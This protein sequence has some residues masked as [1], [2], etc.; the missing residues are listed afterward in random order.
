MLNII[1]FYFQ[2]ANFAAEDLKKLVNIK[3]GRQWCSYRNM[4]QMEKYVL[5]NQLPILQAPKT[6]KRDARLFVTFRPGEKISNEISV[7]LDY[8]FNKNN[9][10][11]ATFRK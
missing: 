2:L 4:K 11:L 1:L 5:L 3:I 9:S 7:T 8:E 10:V 6:S